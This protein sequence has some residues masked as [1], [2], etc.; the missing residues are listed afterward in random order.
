MNAEVRP[1]MRLGMT[2][3]AMKKFIKEELAS[4][5]TMA[6]SKADYATRVID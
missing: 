6:K 1:H 3:G 4:C 2:Y 5:D